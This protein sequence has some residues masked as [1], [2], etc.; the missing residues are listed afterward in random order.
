MTS[1]AS[2]DVIR[3]FVTYDIVSYYYN[4]LIT[5]YDHSLV[6]AVRRC[7]SWAPRSRAASPPSAT[8]LARRTQYSTTL[9]SSI[10]YNTIFYNNIIQYYNL[11][12]ICFS[13][14]AFDMRAP[15]APPEVAAAFCAGDP[16]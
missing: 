1:F 15:V 7:A 12:D 6:Y 8:G 5:C 4:S 11:E 16:A 3:C 10:Y 2:C 9:T 14:A 13:Q